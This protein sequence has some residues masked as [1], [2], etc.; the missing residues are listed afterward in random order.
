MKAKAT[1]CL[2][3]GGKAMRAALAAALA[4]MVC[5]PQITSS[6]AY[7]EN[8]ILNIHGYSIENGDPN[9]NEG[10]GYATSDG[11]ISYCYDASKVGPAN[12]GQEFD[13]VEDGSHASDYIIAR[14]YPSTNQ[15]GGTTWSDADAQGITQLAAWIVAD[16]KPYHD[17]LSFQKTSADKIAAAEALASEANTYQGGD[18]TIDG[19]SS[20]AYCSS[21][22]GIQPMLVGGLGGHV[23]LTKTSGNAA[24]T[25]NDSNY[26]LA[27]AVYGVYDG[28]EL[29]AQFTTDENGHGRTDS[30]VKNGT[31]T[32]KEISA[33]DG[34]VLSNQAYEVTVSGKD[35]NVDAS[36]APVTVKV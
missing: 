36:D 7:A 27:G 2:K 32:V 31:Y 29:V 16:T 18:P 5:V 8:T 12:G 24:I 25:N 17:I 14:G 6:S 11:A 1:Q 9:M 30:K 34:Y 21:K 35:A 33:P 26:T 28:D 4:L 3:G 22:P 20:I 19:C 15:I 10:V 23:T 13:Q